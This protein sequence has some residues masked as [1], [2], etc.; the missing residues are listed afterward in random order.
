MESLDEQIKREHEEHLKK[1]EKIKEEHR[2]VNLAILQCS[3]FNPRS[4][5][6]DDKSWISYK[7]DDI[8][9]VLNILN[10]FKP[11][12]MVHAKYHFSSIDSK[13]YFIREPKNK[14]LIQL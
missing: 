1:I 7:V 6:F 2:L 11:S 10:S 8:I 3:S 12:P 13:D 4:I 5:N 9:D 14:I